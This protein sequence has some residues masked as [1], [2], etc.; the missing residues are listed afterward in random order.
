MNRF[1]NVVLFP[2][3][4]CLMLSI[5]ACSGKNAEYE[6]IQEFERYF[7]PEEY[8]SEYSIISEVFTL[9]TGVDYHIQLDAKCE[10]GTMEISK[11]YEGADEK[12]YSINPETPCKETLAIPTDYVNEVKITVSIEPDTRGTVIGSLLASIK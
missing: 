12:I 5:V 2:V 4:I 6:I 1:K 10:S 9:D 8:D 11:L 7:I 3:A